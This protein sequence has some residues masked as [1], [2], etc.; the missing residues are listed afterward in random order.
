MEHKN[1]KWLDDLDLSIEKMIDSVSINNDECLPLSYENLYWVIPYTDG[2]IDDFLNIC[3]R[4]ESETTTRG[5]NNDEM[6]H[7]LDDLFPEHLSANCIFFNHDQRLSEDINVHEVKIDQSHSCES[8]QDDPSMINDSSV[9]SD[10]LTQSES[11]DITITHRPLHDLI[12]TTIHDTFDEMFLDMMKDAMKITHEK[13]MGMTHLPKALK[14]LLGENLMN[15]I[16]VLVDYENLSNRLIEDLEITVKKIMKDNKDIRIRMLKF[17]GH[18][19][20]RADKADVVV[21]SSLKD[22]VDHY[23]SYCVGLL[24]MKPQRPFQIF[25]ITNDHFA[26]FLEK[27]SNIVKH[28]KTSRDLSTT[29]LSYWK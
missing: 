1:M 26:D 19:H 17:A 21:M 13:E 18:K 23:I 20:S 9:Q 5:I 27:Y 4:K 28:K 8:S 7:T 6:T 10:D 2:M 22:A 12:V 15:Q 3:D 16:V 11:N 14:D 29:I 25:V 24:E